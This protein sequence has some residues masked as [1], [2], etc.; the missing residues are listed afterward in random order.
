MNLSTRNLHQDDVV[1]HITT[2]TLEAGIEPSRI[3]LEITQ[4]SITSDI[5]AIAN[6]LESLSRL[7]FQI[8]L[9]DFGPGSSSI[10]H[11]R[12]LPVTVLKIGQAYVE[13]MSCEADTFVRAIIELSHT[14][15]IL[16][17]ATG[18]ENLDQL[19]QLDAL[20]CDMAQGF[21][22][23]GPQSFTDIRAQ[24]SQVSI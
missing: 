1:N 7:G 12:R 17:G 2:A 3:V 24:L 15:G 23:G 4:S 5:E 20:G 21:L 13:Q 16:V 14:L 11:L 6:K 8:A 19:N 10:D 22:I 18:I 9:D